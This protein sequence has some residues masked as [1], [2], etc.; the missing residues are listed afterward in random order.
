MAKSVPLDLP[1][2]PNKNKKICFNLPLV[3]RQNS[4]RETLKICK[5]T[6]QALTREITISHTIHANVKNWNAKIKPLL[7]D[8]QEKVFEKIFIKPLHTKLSEKKQHKNDVLRNMLE[9]RQILLPTYK[10]VRYVQYYSNREILKELNKD[11]YPWKYNPSSIR[12]HDATRRLTFDVYSIEFN[13]LIIPK[14]K[15]MYDLAS[16]YIS[17]DF[18]SNHYSQNLYNSYVSANTVEDWAAQLQQKI[19][20]YNIDVN[21]NMHH[22]YPQKSNEL[23]RDYELP[24]VALSP[25]PEVRGIVKFKWRKESNVINKKIVNSIKLHGICSIVSAEHGD[26]MGQ[27]PPKLSLK[28]LNR[29]HKQNLYND[30]TIHANVAHFLHFTDIVEDFEVSTDPQKLE[31]IETLLLPEETPAITAS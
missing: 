23:T 12:F 24:T 28:L 18:S 19:S 9:Q 27:I 8:T 5:S 4:A 25:T 30:T 22:M 31:L 2:A 15:I 1:P 20:T 3:D 11:G 17:I 6:L 26:V 13:N 16:G 7:T 29:I 14:A 21:N 10:N